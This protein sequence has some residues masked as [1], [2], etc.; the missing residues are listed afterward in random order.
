MSRRCECPKCGDD[1]SESYT[2]YDPSVG[3]MRSSWWCEQCDIVVDDD[4]DDYAEWE[5]ERER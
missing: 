4:A 5:A 2:E 1:I 3:I